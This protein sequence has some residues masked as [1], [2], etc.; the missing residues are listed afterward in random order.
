MSVWALEGTGSRSIQLIERPASARAGSN[1]HFNN[2]TP[3][4]AGI[5]ISWRSGECEVRVRRLPA[6]DYLGG[7]AIPTAGNDGVIGIL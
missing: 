3:L 7:I 4:N 5:G 6:L 1:R 2:L